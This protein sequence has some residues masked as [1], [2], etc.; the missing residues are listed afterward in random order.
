[1]DD[2]IQKIRE[3]QA[4]QSQ[5]KLDDSR[6][7]RIIDAI[8]SKVSTDDVRIL[9]SSVEK[10]NEALKKL[11]GL[12]IKL[13]SDNEL[14]STLAD[15]GKAVS[16]IQV[17]PVVNVPEP[18]VTIQEK[19]VD[20]SP[21]IDQLKTLE[22]AFKAVDSPTTDTTKLESL[23][24]KTNKAIA[25]LSFP[26]ANFILP[27]KD[28]GGGASQVQL[29]SSGKVPVS[30]SAMT[31]GSQKTQIVDVGG[32]AVTVTG[33]KLDVNA[34]ISGSGGGTSSIDDAAFAV[35]SDSGTPIMGLADET[36]PDSV[37]EGDVGVL[38]MTLSRDLHTTIRD[39]AGNERG[40]NVNASG[41]LA[42]AGPV[43]NAGTFAV[44]ATEADGANTTLGAK[45]DAKSTATDT[46]SVSAMS[47]L[48]QISASVQAPPSQAVTNAGTFAVQATEADG[49]NTTLGAKADAKSTATDTTAVSV[50]SVLKQISASVQAPPSQAVTNAGTFAV[51]ATLAAETTKVLGV[52]RNADGSGN[53]L[54]STSNALDVNLKTSAAS[55]ISTN[56]A[57]MNGVATT[58]GNGASGTGVQR[59][60]IASDSTGQVSPAANATA[61]GCSIYKNTALVATKQA[62]NAS[63]GNL[64]GYHIYNPNTV[65]IY[66]QFYNVAS[67]SVTV[68][69]TAADMI[70]AIPP[71]GW[72]D[73]PSSGPPISFA[74]AMTVAAT[75]TA[76]GSTAPSTGLLVNLW[77]K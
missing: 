44:Q 53:L 14:R 8:G 29:D 52:V 49:A 20:L 34:S 23:I 59:V 54:T 51:Q 25:G 11:D 3:T 47:V 28:S 2:S 62:A 19:E 21:I 13:I 42:V 48:K 75:T 43:T 58:M 33:G 18:K 74:T 39:A 66:V 45:A 60:S 17:K 32:E 68:G 37:N 55:N 16:A 38:R 67:A 7:E 63:A 22:K 71:G 12:D 27:F 5:Q 35:A 46:T 26:S 73:A 36:S 77:Y 57:Q 4:Q 61:T 72:A 64:Y 69:T 30:D 76:T 56:V 65:V 9:G 50:M 70:L 40:A 15:L 6:V 24:K 31:D 41:Q 1:L 10:L